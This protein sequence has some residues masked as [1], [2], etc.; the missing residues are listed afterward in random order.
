M[1]ICNLLGYDK[2]LNEFYIH[3]YASLAL[4]LNFPILLYLA[5]YNLQ[6]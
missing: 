6:L 2:L 5:A 4:L 1:F 3:I